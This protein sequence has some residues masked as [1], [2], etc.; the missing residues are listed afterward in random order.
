MR[1][2][3]PSA[4]ESNKLF[5]EPGTR[6]M[7]PKEQKVTSGRCEIDT[8]LSISSSGV[9]HTGHPGPCTSVI[10]RGSKS[11]SPLLTMVWVCPPQTSMIVHGRV[12]WRRMACASCSAAFWSRYSLRYFTEFLPQRPKLFEVFEDSLRLDLVDDA[13]GE[14]HVNKHI[15]PHFGLWGV[16]QI[17]LFANAAKV[18]LAAAESNVAIIHDF[19]NPPWNRKT[20]D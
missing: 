3:A 2:S 12:T 17:D 11:S 20:H 15:R 9:T 1:T 10:S 8:A 16:R 7:S 4:L 5:D 19:D 6:N 18:H 14:S 13:D